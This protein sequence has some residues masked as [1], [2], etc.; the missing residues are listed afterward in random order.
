M[1]FDDKHKQKTDEP[2]FDLHNHRMY[3]DMRHHI[4]YYLAMLN[5]NPTNT[6]I[7]TVQELINLYNSSPENEE[8]IRN[9]GVIVDSVFNYIRNKEIA[10]RDRREYESRPKIDPSKIYWGVDK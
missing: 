8:V 9:L 1:T 7:I 2:Y 10:E 4:R 6:M 3:D 5:G